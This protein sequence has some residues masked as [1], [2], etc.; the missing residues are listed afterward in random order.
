MV[1]TF[2]GYPQHIVL[3]ASRRVRHGAPQTIIS[4][5]RNAF[6]W[7]QTCQPYAH[8]GRVVRLSVWNFVRPSISVSVSAT[9]T[10][11]VAHGGKLFVYQGG[12]P[13]SIFIIVSRTGCRTRLPVACA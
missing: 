9:T 11:A 8:K 2:C 1:D 5:I 4:G 3:P 6:W 13:P 10:V 12:I 7:F